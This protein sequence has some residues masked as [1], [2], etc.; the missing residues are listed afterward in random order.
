MAATNFTNMNETTKAFDEMTKRVYFV[1]DWD[2]QARTTKGDYEASR[3][4]LE[5]A[6]N[7]DWEISTPAQL[8]AMQRELA[9]LKQQADWDGAAHE[10]AQAQLQYQIAHLWEHLE[11]WPNATYVV[12][13]NNQR[14]EVNTRC[15]TIDVTE[16]LLAD[17]PRNKS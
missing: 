9:E 6:L 12:L 5:K 8:V 11:G 2:E 13:V 3:E 1:V 16:V 4:L 14:V 15:H 17:N 10:K 7:R